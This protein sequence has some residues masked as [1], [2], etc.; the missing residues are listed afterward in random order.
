M[1]KNYKKGLSL[2]NRINR[3][4]VLTDFSKKKLLEAKFPENKISIKPNFVSNYS[5]SYS[6]IKK[7]GFLFA[8]RLSEEKGVYDLVNAH[9]KYN[10]DLSI[11]GDGPLKNYVKNFKKI[12][13]LGFLSK[14]KLRT[15]FIKSKFLIFPSKLYE[16]FGNV[17]I[18]AFA[19]ETIVIAP[20]L[21]S[22]ST[23][24]KDKYNGIL[25][26]HNK[27]NDLLN[28]IKWAIS[29]NA[30]C[31]KIKIN[32]KKILEKKYSEKVNYKLL[33]ELYKKVIEENKLIL[34]KT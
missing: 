32:A 26:D 9:N 34:Q 18:E 12:K 8:S 6:H 21:G 1:I 2:I 15:E 4:I 30:K 19:F 22:M 7:K 16:T 3:F 27:P 11:C 5:R 17:L 24:I 23:I 25:Y 31:E 33:F 13:Y 14:K 10:F 20:N 29:N 28:K